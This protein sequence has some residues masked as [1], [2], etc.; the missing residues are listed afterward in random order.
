ML[1]IWEVLTEACKLSISLGPAPGQSQLVGAVL[2]TAVPGRRFVSTGGFGF[3]VY[4]VEVFRMDFAGLEKDFRVYIMLY[5]Y[6]YS[7][8]PQPHPF[9]GWVSRLLGLRLRPWAY[10]QG[11]RLRYLG[12]ELP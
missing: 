12:S 3:S 10:H 6:K 9:T 7:G 8:R 11:C 1:M 2:G 5:H 4:G